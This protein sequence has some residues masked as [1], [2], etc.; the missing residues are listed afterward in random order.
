MRRRFL[1]AGAAAAAAIAAM[2]T[3]LG[4]VS[5][6]GGLVA[7]NGAVRLARAST[8]I[9][10]HD[11]VEHYLTSFSYQGDVAGI[12]WIVPLPAVPDSVVKGG[13][14]ALQRMSREARPVPQFAG[15][16]DDAA[17]L[18]ARAQVILQTTVDS[19]DITVIKGSGQAVVD[20]ATS[21][22]FSMNDETRA[23]LFSYASAS[24]IFLAAKYDTNAA[25]ARG[26]FQGDGTP[27]LITMHTPR[28][29]VPLEVLANSTDPTSAD[30]FLLTD[31]RP[32]PTGSFWDFA[33]FTPGTQLPGAPGFQ[34]VAQERIPQQLH[35]DL[36]AQP[37]MGWVP[38]DGWFTALSI[39]A[40]G[41]EVTYDMTVD[42]GRIT[43]APM[44]LGPDAVTRPAPGGSQP[45][46]A[47]A[48]GGGS[49]GDLTPALLVAAATLGGALLL[50]GIAFGVAGA[51]ER[52]QRRAERTRTR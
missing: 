20:W 3:T 1:V 30:I 22:S 35:D 21:N 38:T 14:W 16:A 5:A 47:V 50:G 41:N 46:A 4:D 23:H 32:A 48:A 29:W 2:G 18:A 42:A 17:P 25:R 19:L 36:A 44:G 31:E 27:V 7:T 43:L 33:P 12:G 11:G 10:W 24:P 37:N 49:G 34:L 26:F 8:A 45:G 51:V 6:C 9:A 52:R 40:P 15:A 39:D 13:S 28:L